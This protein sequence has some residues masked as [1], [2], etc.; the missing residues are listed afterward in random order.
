MY[1]LFSF[2]SSCE[3]WKKW[4]PWHC[5]WLWWPLTQLWEKCK[6]RQKEISLVVHHLYL[7]EIHEKLWGAVMWLWEELIHQILL[8]NEGRVWGS[9]SDKHHQKRRFTGCDPLIIASRADCYLISCPILPYP[10]YLCLSPIDWLFDIANKISFDG[11]QSIV[12]ACSPQ[13]SHCLSEREY[14]NG[15]ARDVSGQVFKLWKYVL[16]SMGQN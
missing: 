15:V 1:I 13:H 7:R 5:C 4:L 6:Q 14:Y 2:Q 8:D 11:R 3:M 12:S 9:V 16:K 10:M